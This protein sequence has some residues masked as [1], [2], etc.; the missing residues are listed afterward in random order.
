METNFNDIDIEYTD[1]DKKTN[2][3]RIVIIGIIFFLILILVI[4]LILYKFFKRI[5]SNNID[6]AKDYD[7]YIFAINCPKA[8]CYSL[9]ETVKPFCFETVK[10][11]EK[12]KLTIHGMWPSIK[13]KTLKEVSYINC[14]KDK[15]IEVIE[16]K[17]EIFDKMRKYWPSIVHKEQKNFWSLE[18]NK[19]GYCYN[20]RKKIKP[21]NYI[22]FFKEAVRVFEDK[23]LRDIITDL[24]GINETYVINKT[25]LEEDIK[26]K[27]NATTYLSC[28]HTNDKQYVS[29]F[30]FALDL[31][32]NFT[33]N[34]NLYDVGKYKCNDSS[35]LYLLFD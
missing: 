34:K 17:N 14:N 12:G 13:N 21:N 25:K 32:Y 26:K 4:V 8:Y 3:K 31:N 10:K 28:V 9:N 6:M 30:W 19:H 1:Q 20:I 22:E 2:K 29:E 11:L 24:Y 23:K 35:N 16:E 15:Y 27:L 33:T 18:Y 5:N 7:F